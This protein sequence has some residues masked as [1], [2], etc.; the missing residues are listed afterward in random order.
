MAPCTALALAV[1]AVQ[2]AVS[3]QGCWRGARPGGRGVCS[4]RLSL[5]YRTCLNG[6]HQ[7]CHPH[8]HRVTLAP[9]AAWL[10][11]SGLPC[12]CRQERLELLESENDLLLAQ[13]GELEEEMGRLGK[14]LQAKDSQVGSFFGSWL[15]WGWLVARSLLT[16]RVVC[17]SQK[18][19]GRCCCRQGTGHACGGLLWTKG[20][21]VPAADGRG[22]RG[23]MCP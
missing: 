22:G 11:S 20:G 19:V 9:V 1:V 14:L 6:T 18:G 2:R 4:C 13:Q 7:A 21:G 10:H 5:T 16:G 12:P 17:S 8:H 3:P 15:F 23:R